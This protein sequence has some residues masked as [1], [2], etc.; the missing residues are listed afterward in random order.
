M[1]N[2][3]LDDGLEQQRGMLDRISRG[4]SVAP[5][6][7]RRRRKDGTVIDVS[8]RLSPLLERG[9]VVGASKIVRDITEKKRMEEGTRRA[10]AYLASAVGSIQD[11][12]ALYD[13]HD[14]LVLVNSAFR[15]AFG[16]HDAVSG[17]TYS[18]MLDECLRGNV[19]VSDSADDLRALLT[20][21]HRAPSGTVEL[22]TSSGHFLRLHEQRTPEGGSVCV[23][24]DITVDA[25]REQ[26]L[27]HAQIQAEAASAAK[28]EFLSSMSHELRTPL[29]AILG[30]SELMQRDR[31]EPLTTRQLDRLQHV[32]RGGEHLLRLI[33]DILDLSHIEAG[34]VTMS[35]EP[36]SVTSLLEQVVSQL[37]PLASRQEISLAHEQ[38]GGE[39]AIVS[40]DHTRLSQI[41]MNFGSNALKYGRRGGHATFRVTQLARARVRVSIVDDGLGIASDK[42]DKI[43]EPFQRAGQEAGPIEGT[44]IGLAISKR[45]AE[46]MG[47][48]VGFMSDE[49]RGSEFW[50]DLRAVAATASERLTSGRS[51][52]YESPL[53]RGG[54]KYTLVYV[55]DNPSNIALMK[56]VMEDLPSI[57]ML[58]A[59]TA[60]AGIELVRERRPDVV[61]MD[62]NLPGMNGIEAKRVLAGDPE[63]RRIPVIALS[64]AALPRD[65]MRADEAGFVRYLTK[66]IK[67]EEV[68][69]ALEQILALQQ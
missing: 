56:A 8:V 65:T 69:T 36:V 55:E 17:Q 18:T 49:G 59:S 34:R 45:L 20:A 64:A 21:Y 3:M 29:N 25:L 32:H 24:V 48:D 38:A 33:N 63:T 13:E 40:A 39:Q 58:T 35:L 1:E 51:D 66:P 23:Y 50:I 27:R 31:K 15:Q 19:F 6:E 26:E 41:L 54:A 7:A 53:A 57:T 30:F 10:T 46:L 61:L 16:F 5:F 60:E 42:R 11:A 22:R 62:I 37:A 44:G 52:A 68:T 47:G 2:V 67:L 9:A 12:F 43:F 4:E 14:R 28:S